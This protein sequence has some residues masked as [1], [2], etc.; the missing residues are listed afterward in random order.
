LGY[1]T[2]NLTKPHVIPSHFYYVYFFCSLYSLTLF[3]VLFH[4]FIS[5]FFIYLFT[6]ILFHIFN[7]II[8]FF[9]QCASSVYSI[10]KL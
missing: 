6:N 4:I 5:L 2:T 10:P 3:F 1:F 9:F 8:G 7:C